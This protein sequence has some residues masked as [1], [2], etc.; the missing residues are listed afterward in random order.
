MV[1]P[2]STAKARQ[3]QGGFCSISAT[4]SCISLPPKSANTIG[5]NVCGATPRRS[6]TCNK[7]IEG[8]YNG[9]VALTES[10]LRGRRGAGR[11]VWLSHRH[12]HRGARG[13]RWRRRCP[14]SH[15]SRHLPPTA[16]GELRAAAAVTHL[17]HHR[18]FALKPALCYSARIH[19]VA[20]VARMPQ[21]QKA[22]VVV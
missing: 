9:D 5:W 22:M 11:S 13:Q 8:R 3:T 18:L 16:A 19:I 1:C 12:H 6:S 4:S 20:L 10:F 2:P 15:Q 7:K 14:P 17:A 21:A